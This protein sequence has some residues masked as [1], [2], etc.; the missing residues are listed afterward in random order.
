MNNEAKKFFFNELSYQNRGMELENVYA[1]VFY[2][3]VNKGNIKK[4]Y[5]YTDKFD[6]FVSKVKDYKLEYSNDMA[7]DIVLKRILEKLP[8]EIKDEIK[9]IFVGFSVTD[10]SLNAGAYKPFSDGSYL[11][12]YNVMLVNRISIISGLLT[13]YTYERNYIEKNNIMCKKSIEKIR[14][15]YLSQILAE[16]EELEIIQQKID[17]MFNTEMVDYRES[18]DII[19]CKLYQYT[20]SF[21]LCHEMGHHILLHTQS[22][23]AGFASFFSINDLERQKNHL[24]EFQ[25]DSFGV[26]ATLEA[27]SE[28]GEY[29]PLAIIGMIIPILTFWIVN[30]FLYNFYSVIFVRRYSTGVMYSKVL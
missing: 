25:A 11:I 14:N 10:K 5:I 24:Q 1:E 16:N 23:L 18:F 30:T 2:A 28:N 15:L 29:S 26:H 27:F 4:E 6:D 17:E 19:F 12:T 22:L 8:N 20:S 7:T 13:T 9:N 21:I 3:G